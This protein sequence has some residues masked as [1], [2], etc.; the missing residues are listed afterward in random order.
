[1]KPQPAIWVDGATVPMRRASF[2]ARGGVTRPGYRITTIC[3]NPLCV[4]EEHI[5]QRSVSKVVGGPR[6]PASRARL[7][8]ALRARATL[9][10]E[11][12]RAIRASDK[13]PAELSAEYGVG[14][15][16]IYAVLKHRSWR[17]RGVF[18]GLMAVAR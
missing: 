16:A 10:M 12:A 7:E 11:K 13:T 5:V 3:E 4:A 14:V 2:I 1:M 15:T 9:D 6:T 18:S 17:E 8:A